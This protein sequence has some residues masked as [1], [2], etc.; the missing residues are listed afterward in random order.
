MVVVLLLHDSDVPGMAVAAAVAAAGSLLLAAH[1][2]HTEAA[3]AA[4]V[5]AV[6]AD[7][8]TG[9]CFLVAPQR[10]GQH[11]AQGRVEGEGEGTR[12]RRIWP[13]CCD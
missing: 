12:R 1:T 3:A 8:P 13:C 4:D 7:S 5:A 11:G 2:E 10:L 9:P 6:V